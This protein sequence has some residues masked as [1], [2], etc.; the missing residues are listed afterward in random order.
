MLWRNLR[1]WLDANPGDELAPKLRAELSTEP[2]RY[3]TYTRQLL[4]WGVFA[5]M[6][7]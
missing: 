3:V 5:L 7:R 1:I 2:S 4:G 6:R